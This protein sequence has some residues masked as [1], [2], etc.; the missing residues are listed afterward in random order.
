MRNAILIAVAFVATIPAANWMIGNVGTLCIPD[1]PCLIPVGFGL[2]APS[3]VLL[4]GLALVLRD[5]LQHTA[6]RIWVT[7]AIA[8]GAGLSAL[9]APPALVI[10]SAVAF[11]LSEL[12]DMAVYTPLARKRLFVAVAA[13]GVVGAV[14]DSAIFLQLAFDSLDYVAGNTVGKIWASLAAV[15]MM[16][17]IRRRLA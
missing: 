16:V 14:V 1:G 9:V 2:H 11:L 12:A 3:G 7:V 17:M 5:W 6:G 8:A 13:S 4:I 10:A 15:P